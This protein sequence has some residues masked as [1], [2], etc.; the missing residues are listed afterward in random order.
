M[1]VIVSV[2]KYILTF[3]LEINMF[4]FFNW[5]GFYTVFFTYYIMHIYTVVQVFFKMLNNC[6]LYLLK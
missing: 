4:S 5:H 2:F 3:S 1:K 6:F